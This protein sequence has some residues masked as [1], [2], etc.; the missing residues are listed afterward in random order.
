MSWQ[1]NKVQLHSEE[2]Q[3]CK[4]DWLEL[5]KFCEMLTLSKVIQETQMVFHIQILID[6]S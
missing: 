2:G 3:C 4:H 6:R 1:L 5:M